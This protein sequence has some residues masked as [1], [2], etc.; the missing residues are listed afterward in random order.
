VHA[1]CLA[2][3]GEGLCSGVGCVRGNGDQQFI[4]ASD[5]CRFSA[6]LASNP[7][8]EEDRACRDIRT[9]L[10]RSGVEVDDRMR[11]FTHRQISR[12]S[13]SLFGLSGMSYVFIRKTFSENAK[14]ILRFGDF[15][16]A[17]FY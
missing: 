3:Q 1:Q 8:A 2:Q 4:V 5:G 15:V 12:W 9:N 11:R 16:R 6:A 17:D 13:T 14:A 7:A 10:L